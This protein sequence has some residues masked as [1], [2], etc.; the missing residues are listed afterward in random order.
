MRNVAHAW[1]HLKLQKSTTGLYVLALNEPN[2][3][4]DLDNLF[5]VHVLVNTHIPEGTAIVLDTNISCQA[6]TRL[7]MEIM[8]NQYTT[9]AF[10]SNAWQFRAECRETV[11]VIR[12]TAIATLTGINP[13]GS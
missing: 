4:G 8:A 5:G 13:G 11:A 10:E 2:L 6:W 9:Y 7:G 1:R 12:P 3:L